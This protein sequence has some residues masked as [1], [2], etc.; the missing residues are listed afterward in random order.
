MKKLLK[1]LK[2]YTK[3]CIISPLFKFLEAIFDLLVPIVVKLII[4]EGIG[5]GEGMSLIP[6]VTGHQLIWILVGVLVLFAIVGLSCALVAQYFAARAAVGASTDLRRDLF[7]HIQH[8]SYSETDRIGTST[9]ITRLTGD[10]NQIQSGINFTLR[11]LLRSPIIVLGAAIMAF[12]VDPSSAW[13]FAVVIPVLAV[14]IFAIML[15]N[16]PHYKAVQKNLDRVTALTRENLYGVRVIRAFCKEE[17]EVERFREANE[18]HNRMQNLVGRISALMNPLTLVVVNGG[19]IALLLLGADFVHFGSM[20]TGDVVAMTNYMSQILVELIKFATTVFTVNKALASGDRVQ[21]V[22]EIPA[23]MEGRKDSNTDPADRTAVRF[24]HVSL[25][26][27]KGAEET[28]T[29]IDFAIDPGTTVGIIGST[30]SGKTSLINLIPRFYDVTSGC[31]RVMGRDVRSYETDELRDRVAL[32]PQKAVLVSGTVRSNLLWGNKHASDEELWQAL[33]AAQAK[34]FV[35]KLPEGLDAPVAVGGKNLSGGQ[36]QRL[37]IAR[38]LVKK[39]D[40]LILDDASSAL[41]YATDAALRAS[42][43]ALPTH[44]TV[45]LISQRTSSIRHADVILVME[46]GALVGMGRHD[47]LLENCEV[48]REIHHSQYQKGGDAQ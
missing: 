47:E 18:A 12:T 43:K 5:R 41:D 19:V 39:A 10:V 1:Y 16:V 38:A 35:E 8:I 44:P 40:I 46:D 4:D 21:A 17:D 20:T 23:G 2:P 32:V 6:G 25:T 34:E 45:F 42:L 26:Y 37:T 31:V 7:A 14:I 3:E 24:S 13:V 15:R 30:G 33:E 48:Y 9:L 11:L 27:N 29:D 36:R 28:L 22:F